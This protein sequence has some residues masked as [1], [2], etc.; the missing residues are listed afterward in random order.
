MATVNVTVIT[1]LYMY[2]DKKKERPALICLELNQINYLDM[3]MV[4]LIYL[5]VKVFILE[6][7]CF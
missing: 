6:A 4:D 2:I 7:F 5:L 1:K 3:V